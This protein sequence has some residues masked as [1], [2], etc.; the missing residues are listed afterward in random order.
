M[1]SVSIPETPA[2]R[3]ALVWLDCFERGEL[4]LLRRF[5]AERLSGAALAVLGAE[6]QARWQCDLY[7]DTSGLVPAQVERSSETE[8]SLL[9]RARVTGEW[10]R[11][12]LAVEREPPHVIERFGVFFLAPWEPPFGPAVADAE[13]VAELRLLA[14]RLADLDCF[15]GA[16]LLAHGDDVRLECA[17]GLARREDS[18]PNR[19]D[20]RFNIG[21]INKMFTAVAVAQLAQG[22]QLD[23][24]DTLRRHL[25]DYPRSVSERITIHQLLTHTSGLDGFFSE[26]LKAGHAAVAAVSDYLPMFADEPLLFEPGTQV[27]YSNA[28]YAV[29]GALIEQVS[30]QDYYEYVRE[31]I[32]EPA[33]MRDTDSSDLDSDEPG[34]AR[35]YTRQDADGRP[36]RLQSNLD[37][38][39]LPPRGG[40]FGC[41][42]STV[43]DLHR[44]GRALLRHELLSPRLTELVLSGKVQ[45]GPNRSYGYG[46]QG[47]CFAGLRSIGHGGGT[48][49]ANARLVLYPELSDT[50]VVLSNT[51][52]PIADRIVDHERRLRCAQRAAGCP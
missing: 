8:L 17:H 4:D 11:L 33:G 16:V 15:S 42:F 47:S 31:H 19:P 21:S 49:G 9:V 27:S 39:V 22:G 12:N 38:W 50:L 45:M 20:T 23:F 14:E 35:G 28:G 48:P 3:Q 52:P 5:A 26:R 37:N 10:L 1:E 13:L 46:F 2:G 30:G 36:T 40:P 41:G 7:R 51:D 24:G 43:G 18:V 6:A 29:L 34:L 32:Y 25:P 44:F